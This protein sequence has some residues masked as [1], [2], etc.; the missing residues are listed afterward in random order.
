MPGDATIEDHGWAELPRRFAAMPEAALARFGLD[1]RA[2]FLAARPFPHVVIDDLFDHRVLDRIAA[3]FPEHDSPVWTQ[4][5]SE[6]ENKY[7][8][9]NGDAAFAPVIQ[10]FLRY[11]NSSE[12][13]RFCELVS[14][15]VGLIPDPHFH[16]AGVTQVLSGGHLG[17]HEDFNNH[18]FS[19]LKRTLSVLI[20]LNR[21]WQE[22]YG[23]D[24]ELWD[25]GLRECARTIAPLFNRTVLFLNVEKAYH[26]HPKPLATPPQIR[27]KSL[28]TIYYTNPSAAQGRQ[29]YHPPLF[30]KPSG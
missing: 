12:F 25:A 9:S 4:W 6:H 17:L 28:A 16:G 27:R 7:A 18:R 11:L 21:D 30:E 1:K 26:G 5:A 10:H 3:E 29:E 24:L 13:V 8:A 23:G 14:G 15:V 20:Y 22:S 19:G 2:E